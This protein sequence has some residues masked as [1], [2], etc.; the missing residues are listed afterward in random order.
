MQFQVI[1][2]Q[3]VLLSFC[4][5]LSAHQLDLVDL[6]FICEICLTPLAPE[7]LSTTTSKFEL[8]RAVGKI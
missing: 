8:R 2:D 6:V 7:I 5:R 1:V 4:L 3:P